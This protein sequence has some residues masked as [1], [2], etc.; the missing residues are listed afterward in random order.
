MRLAQGKG[1]KTFNGMYKQD[2]ASSWESLPPG[3]EPNS[4]ATDVHSYLPHL[5]KKSSFFRPNPATIDN[6]QREFQ[7]LIEALMSDDM[8]A[9]VK[10]IRAS[11]IIT[12]FFGYWRR[13]LLLSTL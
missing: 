4:V 8:P 1:V 9:L 3:P 10:E 11:R 2:M 7:A 5:T 6:R 13:D 12:D